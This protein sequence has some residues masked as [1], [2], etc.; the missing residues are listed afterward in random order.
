M[1]GRPEA[2][3][4][5]Y[6]RAWAGCGSHVH[7]NYKRSY[8][9]LYEQIACATHGSEERFRDIYDTRPQDL[10]GRLVHLEALE[11]D[12][13]LENLYDITCGEAYLDNKAFD[14]KEVWG[15]LNFGP[16]QTLEELQNS[17]IFQRSENEAAFAIIENVTDRLLGVV[18][19]TKDEPQNLT[20]QLEPPIIK[21]SSEGSA[22]P[23]EACFLVLEKLFALGYRRVQL[24][25][26]SQDA[27]NKKLAARLGFTKEADLPKHMIVKD[28]SR[29]SAIYGMLNNDWEKGARSFLYKKLHGAK[30]CLIDEANNKKE[31]EIDE[32]NRGLAEQKRIAEEQEEKTTTDKKKE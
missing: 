32:Q 24:A 2:R 22:E 30:R 8:S 18:M 21:P 13:H 27:V 3:F 28:A 25:I 14:P 19:L 6:A 4:E 20:I 29:D 10:I 15:F 11:V 17:H 16:F 1:S 5:A 9:R 12:R 7:R 31:E 23:I 26:D